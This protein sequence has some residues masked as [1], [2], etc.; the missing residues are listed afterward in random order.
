MMKGF[1]KNN[2]HPFIFAV[3][4]VLFTFSMNL[5]EVE[6][7]DTLLPFAFA[8][9]M[10][11]S[12]YCCFYFYYRDHGAAAILTSVTQLCFYLYGR[13]SFVLAPYFSFSPY[14]LVFFVFSMVITFFVL[15]VKE[16]KAKLEK[17]S[18]P[19]NIAAITLVVFNLIPIFSFYA[20][21]LLLG[22]SDIAVHGKDSRS[23]DLPDIYY[24]IPDSYPRNDNLI[25][26]FNYDN[27]HFLNELKERGFYIADESMSNYASTY[28]SLASSLN[29][30][31]MNE[32][33]NDRNN[34]QSDAY[35]TYRLYELVENNQLSHSMSER[36][37]VFVNFR[38]GG[39]PTDSM[40]SADIELGYFSFRTNNE[41]FFVFLG[42]T[43]LSPFI[44][45]WSVVNQREDVLYTL[46]NLGSIAKMPEPTL[47][48]AHFIAPHPP[49][50]FDRNGNLPDKSGKSMNELFVNQLIY[51][52]KKLISSI[53]EILSTSEKPPIIIIQGDH[54][55]GLSTFF[56]SCPDDR[57]FLGL[58]EA[59]MVERMKI[60]NAYYLPGADYGELYPSISPVNTFRLVSNIYFNDNYTLLQDKSYFSCWNMDKFNF[61]ELETEQ[62]TP[63]H[64][65]STII[66]SATSPQ[67]DAGMKGS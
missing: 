33:S 56:N 10:A 50:L 31:Y 30:K 44:D 51:V 6:V 52:N 32:L 57:G 53:D 38:S 21:I 5:G 4:F 63:Y 22:P 58:T 20:P 8:F 35:N 42:S 13:V 12:V 19:L 28:L 9:L 66:I 23:F 15:F 34:S 39:G 45:H 43:V 7:V 47:T 40:S 65:Q 27:T 64:N 48:L 60:L 61:R 37:Y 55:T 62:D 18:P 11:I 49:F 3:Y 2:C 67:Q 36:G 54:G 24:I 29:L 16:N 25:N 59:Q 14:Y 17:L 41:F 26:V 1:D 46:E